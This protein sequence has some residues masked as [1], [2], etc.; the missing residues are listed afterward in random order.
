MKRLRITCEQLRY[1]AVLLVVLFI[2]VFALGVLTGKAHAAEFEDLTIPVK[3][4]IAEAGGEKDRIT[5]MQAV[6]NV[7]RNRAKYRGQTFDQ[8]CL[9]KWQF[10][11]WNGG[12]EKVDQFVLKNRSV[13]NDA[14]TAWQLSANEDITG[15]SDLYH[16]NYVRPKW[17]FS[18][19]IRLQQYGRHIFYKEIK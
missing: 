1:I 9:A 12:Q 14:L 17:D 6:A 10:S 11:C 18:K 7:I 3:T 5:A 8:V 15:G 13:W 19:T 4:L 2:T 16:A